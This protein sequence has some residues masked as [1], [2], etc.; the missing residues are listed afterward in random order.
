MR[1]VLICT[2][3]NRLSSS[4]KR[5]DVLRNRHSKLGG[6]EIKKNVFTLMRCLSQI[7]FCIALSFGLNTLIESN[8][9]SIT[10]HACPLVKV[11]GA[12][13]WLEVSLKGNPWCACG[14]LHLLTS[15]KPVEF[16]VQ[17]DFLCALSALCLSE[18][19]FGVHVRKY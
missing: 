17:P 14:L 9:P 10:A 18:L 5:W 16:S 3:Q 13:R 12:W 15:G 1:F 11:L 6:K 8:L 4:L 2:L 19:T 7:P